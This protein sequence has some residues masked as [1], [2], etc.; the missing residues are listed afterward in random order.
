MSIVICLTDSVDLA[1]I[2]AVFV[3]IFGQWHG[4]QAQ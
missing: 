2:G 4:H 1:V 3:F